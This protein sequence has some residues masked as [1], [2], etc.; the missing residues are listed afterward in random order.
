MYSEKSS[1]S[2][3][4]DCNIGTL[5]HNVFVE[6]PNI[7]YTIKQHA[8]VSNHLSCALVFRITHLSM[9]LVGVLTLK[10]PNFYF[11]FV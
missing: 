10:P 1:F 7:A 11:F 4:W 2:C 3:S 6:L 8:L 5:S 9:C